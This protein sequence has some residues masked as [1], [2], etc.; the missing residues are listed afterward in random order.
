[1][2]TELPLSPTSSE[3]TPS[4]PEPGETQLPVPSV[5]ES[6]PAY[7][8]SIEKAESW[9]REYNRCEIPVMRD[10]YFWEFV[11][12]CARDFY[13]VNIPQD[14]R[15]ADVESKI[16]TLMEQKNTRSRRAASAAIF[17]GLMFDNDVF[18]DDH[19][20]FIFVKSLDHPTTVH[21]FEELI[22]NCLPY[23]TKC[24][25]K[26][27]E[28]S[29]TLEVISK[30]ET[31]SKSETVSKPKTISKPKAISKPKTT[32]TRKTTSKLKTQKQN[33]STSNKRPSTHKI[34]KQSSGTRHSLRIAN[35]QKM[36]S[37]N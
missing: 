34:S 25:R 29:P 12:E 15:S 22:A 26:Y 11:A 10:E 16:K 21:E 19:Q 24:A 6:L 30:Q 35:I 3:A 33:K 5:R 13:G 32:S 37:V 27:M 36:A 14:S 8:I 18:P 2:N 28:E 4:E 20:G 9:K 17:Q 23:L 31:I 1:M 7:G